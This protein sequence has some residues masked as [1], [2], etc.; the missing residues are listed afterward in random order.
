[1]ITTASMLKAEGR[2]EGRVEGRAEV[3]LRQVADKWTPSAETEDTIRSGTDREFRVWS[4][5][6]LKEQSQ[7]GFLAA[8]DNPRYSYL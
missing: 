6:I 3:L 4:I 2:V 8:P 7:E 5:A 1:M